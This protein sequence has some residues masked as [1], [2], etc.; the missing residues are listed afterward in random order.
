MAVFTYNSIVL[1]PHN[2]I[3]TSAVMQE[4]ILGRYLTGFVFVGSSDPQYLEE[5]S[6]LINSL[7]IYHQQSV[8]YSL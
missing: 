5:N 2:V 4:I 3:T 6:S 8:G 7:P 1:H